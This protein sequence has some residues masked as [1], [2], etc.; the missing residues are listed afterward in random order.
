MMV[1]GQRTASGFR[2]RKLAAAVAW[3]VA[4]GLV[5]APAVAQDVRV[6]VTGSNIKRVESESAS[7][8][9]VI[10]RQD[11]ERTGAQT[12]GEV[13]Q[14]LPSAGW[15]ID[16]RVTNGFTSGASALNVRN[17]GF[18]STLVLLN[19]RRLPTYPFAQRTTLGSQQFQDL[20]A[21]P[22]AAV[23]RIE[24]LK[25]GASAIYGADAVGG[26][27][28]IILR[29]NYQGGE[30]SAA[31]GIA[32]V[33]DAEMY[34]VN[35][36][37]GWG[38]LAKDKYNIFLNAYYFKRDAAL[39][40]DRDFAN[41]EDLRSRGGGDLRSGFG[42]PGT[43]IDLETGAVAYYP[44]C[45]SVRA[46]RCRYNRA[47]FGGVLPEVERA[48]AMLK[49]EWAFNP[50][51]SAFGELMYSQNKAY[52]IGFPAPSTD[53]AGIGSNILPVGHPANPFPNEALIAHRYAD[54]GNRDTDSTGDTW[55]G[56]LGLKGT[57]K[58]WDWE[59]Y[60]S[61]SEIDIEE[62]Q[63]NNVLSTT[64]LATINDRSYNFLNPFANPASVTERLRY[65]GYHTGNSRFDDYGA[66][67]SG[68][69]WSLPAGPILA[70]VGV[71][72]TTLEVEDIPDPNIAAGNALGI[73]ASAAFGRQDLTAVFGEIIVPVV[74][75]LEIS[76][77]LR[78]D[79]YSESGD[80]SNTSPKVGVRWQP[81]K[82]LLLRGTYS[83]AFRAPSIFETTTAT[84]SS[85][86]FGLVDPTRCI[87]GN[88]PDCNLDVKLIQTG[89]PNLKPEESK[90]WNIGVVW[91]PINNLTL[92]LDYWN[93]KRDDEIS[94]FA[95][96]TL[97]NLFPNNP[98]IV[99][100]DP[101]GTI[102]QVN[103]VPVQ[104]AGTKTSGFDFDARMR[105]P[106]DSW[107][108]FSPRLVVSYVDEYKFK[109]IG[110]SGEI[111]E[112]N[113][114][115][116]YNQPRVRASWDLGWQYGMHEL[117]LNGY[118]VH[119]FDQLNPIASGEDVDSTAVWN[120][121]W[122]WNFAKN[123]SM[124]LAVTN[125]FDEDPPFSNETSASNAGYNPSQHDP[126]GRYYQLGIT[127]RF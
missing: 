84:Q 70:A 88:E 108:T 21:I 124:N 81:T 59:V 93:V 109:T 5:A 20:N 103:N 120:F 30:A 9:E 112:F 75:G 2:Q 122:K 45:E 101:T 50:N 22:V 40:A 6:E 46:N 29:T 33:G 12:I 7:P 125:L 47:S 126:R 39:S 34:T 65:N 98:A 77:A 18:N 113:Y 43:R 110:D 76:G 8:I 36:T 80:F 121:F 17:L 114:N 105:I 51:V 71:Q 64:A 66:R 85:F 111:E 14:F 118:Y 96:Q 55:R 31:A 92:S 89:N 83:E 38:D 1:S 49:G 91:E 95:T 13:L 11:I 117:S 26:V 54:V 97:I 19:G 86:E 25:D 42:Y 116:T 82:N 52:N 60:G 78:Y 102:D 24:I 123:W 68:E 115:G 63:L 32:E 90:I 15:A 3:A 106:T 99:V 44:N 41:N 62:T 37:L 23:Q 100:R 74:K 94:L 35:A 10:T 4:A 107:G 127:Y 119:S 57:Y 72:Y 79:K 16:D 27:V 61:W 56:V 73:S 48:G 67:A 53:D 104:L 87:T 28:N 58:T 69:V